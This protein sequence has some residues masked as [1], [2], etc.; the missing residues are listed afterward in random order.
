MKLHKKLNFTHYLLL[1]YPSVITCRAVLLLVGILH[2]Y[3]MIQYQIMLR[4]KKTLKTPDSNF[5]LSFPI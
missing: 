3:I 5:L 1:L 4:C 2:H